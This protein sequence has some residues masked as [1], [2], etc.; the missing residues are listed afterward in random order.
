MFGLSE[1]RKAGLQTNYSLSPMRIFTL[2]VDS[3]DEVAIEL[4]YVRAR[5]INTNALYDLKVSNP[6][7]LPTLDYR[8]KWARNQYKSN[9]NFKLS[10]IIRIRLLNALKNKNNPLF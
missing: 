2:T 8:I 9:P 6:E 7:V 5:E 3:M 1:N 4:G 10:Q